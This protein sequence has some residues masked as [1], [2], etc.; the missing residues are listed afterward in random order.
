MTAC[1]TCIYST[2]VTEISPNPCTA[3]RLASGHV[4][5][6]T[7][8]WPLP[9]I[10]SHAGPSVFSSTGTGHHQLLTEM[11][12]NFLLGCLSVGTCSGLYI[13]CSLLIQCWLS[14]IKIVKMDISIISNLVMT[15]RKLRHFSKILTILSIVPNDL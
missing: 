13:S 15:N 5:K 4:Q 3:L 6:I 8:S 11:P 1:F 7:N 12:V 10:M 9:G 2:L 14:C